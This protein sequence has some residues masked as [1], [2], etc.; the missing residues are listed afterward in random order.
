MKNLISD[1]HLFY[2]L[3]FLVGEETT[4][5]GSLGI[6]PRVSA[7]LPKY[8]MVSHDFPRIPT[9][10]PTSQAFV[11]YGRGRWVGRGR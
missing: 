7:S 8:K 1:F 2:F 5:N 3:S 10:S 11:G 6:E 9:D 4:K